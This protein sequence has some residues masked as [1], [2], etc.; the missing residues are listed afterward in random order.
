VTDHTIYV[1]VSPQRFANRTFVLA[2]PADRRDDLLALAD[3]LCPATGQYSEVDGGYASRLLFSQ[4]HR[5]FGYD[6]GDDYQPT[7]EDTDIHYAHSGR[8]QPDTCQVCHPPVMPWRDKLLART[9]AAI[10][11]RLG[12]TE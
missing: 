11:A 6:P 7:S 4:P 9:L 12:G 8:A 1:E 2:A 5:A 3:R 10:E